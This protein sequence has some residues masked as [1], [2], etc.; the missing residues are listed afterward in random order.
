[1]STAFDISTFIDSDPGYYGGRPFIR[2]KRVTVQRIGILYSEGLNAQ[3]IA[4]DY[5]LCLP[6]VHAALCYYLANRDEID[7][8]IKEQDAEYFRAAAAH[9]SLRD[10]R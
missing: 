7:A 1:M 5:N 4:E 9:V 8:D 2:D 3:E 6:E 10:R